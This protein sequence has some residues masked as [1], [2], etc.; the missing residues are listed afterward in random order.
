M[1]ANTDIISELSTEANFLEEIANKYGKAKKEAWNA[2]KRRVSKRLLLATRAKKLT[3]VCPISGIVS[4]LE[5]PAIPQFAAEYEHPLSSVA[6]CRGLAQ[7][8]KDYLI[9]LDTQTLAGILIVLASA[10][11][12]F[13]F[14]E[15]DSGAQRN[16]LIRTA[17][18][19]TII[20]AILIVENQ[21]HNRNTQFLPKLSLVRDIV[22]DVHNRNI[23]VRLHNYLSLLT[24]AIRKPDTERYDENAKPKRIGR[25]LYIRDVEAKERKLSFLARQEISKAKKEL[26]DDAKTAKTLAANI[27]KDGLLR[28]G[29]K[30]F[31]AQLVSDNGMGLVMADPMLIDMLLSQKLKPI[32]GK[33]DDVKK[34]IKILEKD[35]SILRKDVAEEDDPLPG[36]EEAIEDDTLPSIEE[37]AEQQLEVEEEAH[38]QNMMPEPPAG[39]SFI[40]R[41]LW[42]K[43]YLESQRGKQREISVAP[44]IPSTHTYIPTAEKQNLGKE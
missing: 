44:E 13:R 43:K 2:Q 40:E 38:V 35:R 30:T 20:D 26:A 22:L 18:K 37:Q 4:L 42:K 25:P 1:N 32:L 41:T 28:S 7:R 21:V 33:S 23:D 10:Y 9:Q 8:G 27:V 16:A 24:E 6:N 3:V 14:Q 11:D 19:D 12:L 17:G 36:Q 5:I 15:S 34:L 29:L 31:I 39:L